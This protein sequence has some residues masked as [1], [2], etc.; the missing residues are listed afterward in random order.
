MQTDGHGSAAKR[1]RTTEFDH[2]LF[3]RWLR[4]LL[5]SFYKDEELVIADFLGQHAALV[6]DTVIAHILG[7]QERQL[8]QVVE[9]R[10]VPDCLVEQ[11]VDGTTSKTTYRISPMAIVMT[12]KRLQTME[13][14][15][16]A[17]SGEGYSCAKCNSFYTPLQ[18]MALQDRT[19]DSGSLN[20]VCKACNE[21]LD[22][23]SKSSNSKQDALR[24]FRLQCR[25]LLLLTRDLQESPLIIES[26]Q[27]QTFRSA[28]RSSREPPFG[29]SCDR[30]DCHGMVIFHRLSK[31]V[32]WRRAAVRVF[33]T[34][35]E[36]T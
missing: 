2:P 33:G 35:A 24:R 32:V 26:H 19:A 27:S 1:Q 9:R 25:D 12:G 18:A 4:L 3:L 29:A 28:S 36:K 15:L 14:G 34:D 31:S 8:R 22:F 17:E 13:D 23:I 10:L 21:E 11:K 5:V 6:K 20:F 16:S 30:A 7:L